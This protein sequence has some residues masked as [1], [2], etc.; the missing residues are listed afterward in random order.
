MAFSLVSS[1][2]PSVLNVTTW[3]SASSPF[4]MVIESSMYPG[5]LENA[6]LT[7]LLHPPQT[8]PVI[9]ATYM[10]SSAIAV[11]ARARTATARVAISF[12]MVFGIRA[13]R[14]AP[15]YILYTDLAGLS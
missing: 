4:S 7:S 12:F 13:T 1:A 5:R 9:P 3:V 2:E 10:T 11:E 15:R 8:T 14:I 6:E